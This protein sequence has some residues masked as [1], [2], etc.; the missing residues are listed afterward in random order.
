MR[1]NTGAITPKEGKQASEE[2]KLR[3]ENTSIACVPG[4][5]EIKPSPN[6]LSSLTD[7]E[8]KGRNVLVGVTEI[9]QGSL[10]KC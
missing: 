9:R 8:V 4:F 1:F 10:L 6:R 5:I 7:R 3:K 2:R